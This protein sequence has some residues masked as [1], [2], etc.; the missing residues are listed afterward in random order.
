M[1]AV[2]FALPAESSDLI[3]ALQDRT[4]VTS[5][6]PK[7]I[8]GRIDNKEVT[9][10]HTG[11]GRKSCE[12]RID[13]FLATQKP[14]CLIS[15]GFAGAIRHDF[16]VGDVIL[17]ENFSDQRLL[18]E[19]QQI[20]HARGACTAK[21][22][23]SVSVIDSISERIETARAHN[24]AAVDMETEF[25]AKACAARGIPMLSARVISDTL[26]EPFPAPPSVLFD[27]ERQRTDFVKLS[28]HLI[29]HPRA[30][31]ALTRFARQIARARKEL[32]GA[33]VELLRRAEW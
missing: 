29:S 18:S 31:L 9:I 33:L 16:T 5:A 27:I 21:L 12:R 30:V 22:F 14:R 2:S 8:Q 23:T 25:I 3:A 6:E 26:G 20:L 7:T 28:L 32:T 4:S 1:I 19:A 15:S 24:A 17:A 10:F 11:V 13:S